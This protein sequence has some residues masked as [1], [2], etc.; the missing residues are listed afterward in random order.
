MHV[1]LYKI[2]RQEFDIHISQ[3]LEKNIHLLL[4]NKLY[5][6]EIIQNIPI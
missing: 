1:L 4:D 6:F 2:L 5:I 3:I